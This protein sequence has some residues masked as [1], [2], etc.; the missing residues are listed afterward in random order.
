MKADVLDVLAVEAHVLASAPRWWSR[1]YVWRYKNNVLRY[2]V[3]YNKLVSVSW[4]FAKIDMRKFEST[5]GEDY[6]ELVR[7][8]VDAEKI[9]EWV[10]ENF[11]MGKYLEV[12]NKPRIGKSSGVLYG[13]LRLLLE[14]ERFAGISNYVVFVVAPNRRLAVNLYR[15]LVGLWNVLGRA[16]ISAGKVVEMSELSRKV[17]VMRIYQLLNRGDL[18]RRIKVRLYIGGADSCLLN[19]V[20]HFVDKDCINCRFFETGKVPYNAP[21][22]DPWALKLSGYCPFAVSRNDGFIRNSIVVTTLHSFLYYFSRLVP[23]FGINKVILVFDEVFEIYEKSRTVVREIRE[24]PWM[25]NEVKEVVKK[26]NALVEK[27]RKSLKDYHVERIKLVSERLKAPVNSYLMNAIYTGILDSL[28]FPDLRSIRS[29]MAQLINH[30]VELRKRSCSREEKIRLGRL[31]KTMELM[32]SWSFYIVTESGNQ[33]E[34]IVLRLEN[35]RKWLEVNKRSMARCR[36][37]FYGTGSPPIV[38]GPGSIINGIL[39]NWRSRGIKFGVI[40]TSILPTKVPGV[41]FVGGGWVYLLPS[42]DLTPSRSEINPVQ[43]VTGINPCYAHIPLILNATL[44]D[45]GTDVVILSKDQLLKFLDWLRGTVSFEI[46][47]DLDRGVID[48]VVVKKP[49]NKGY[50]YLMYPHGRCS[51]GVDPPVAEVDRVYIV[52]GVR[53]PPPTIA[54][55][56]VPKLARLMVDCSLLVYTANGRGVLLRGGELSSLGFTLLHNGYIEVY[57]NWDFLYDA[58][59]LRQVLGRWFF[60]DVKDIFFAGKFAKYTHYS[61]YVSYTSYPSHKIPWVAEKRK[62]KEIVSPL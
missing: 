46:V 62:R 7:L 43:R 1:Y 61:G 34:R 49:Y 17:V 18:A 26:W 16:I 60:A 20:K 39:E 41:P 35:P 22:L 10:V 29:E 19:K 4:A 48:Y 40:S 57:D 45:S 37:R 42:R 54:P 59:V 47:G 55:V 30:L 23:K 11:S 38:C 13:L 15:Y 44:H 50:L 28:D 52:G 32:L 53:R 33:L 8:T 2:M 58:H 6:D 24:E 14:D 5:V 3:G 27:L 9:S 56:D 51:M 21:L 36:Y 12:V 25:N 31:I